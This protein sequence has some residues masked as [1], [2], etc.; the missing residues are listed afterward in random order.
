MM[1]IGINRW[2]EKTAYKA[3]AKNEP[4]KEA[5]PES[6]KP[7]CPECGCDC[8]HCLGEVK[9]IEQNLRPDNTV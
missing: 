5:K 1:V 6:I 7:H 3:L 4:I 2:G 9:K 8:I